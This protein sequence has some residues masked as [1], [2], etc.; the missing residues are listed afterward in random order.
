MIRSHAE[1]V[2]ASIVT[3]GVGT[4]TFLCAGEC[5]T[6]GLNLIHVFKQ[7]SETSVTNR[8]PARYST[9]NRAILAS[10]LISGRDVHD[11]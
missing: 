7:S 9:L 11:I 10:L 2:D 8:I 5:E 3:V 4:P 6:E 1:L